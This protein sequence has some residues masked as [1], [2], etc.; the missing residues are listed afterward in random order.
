MNIMSVANKT[1]PPDENSPGNLAVTGAS[2]TTSITSR[3]RP[4]LS[5]TDALTQAF[6]LKAL[7]NPTRLRILNLL[8]RYEGVVSVFDIVEN[9]P[10]EQPTISHHLRILRDAGLIDYE[11][12]GLW[13]YYYVRRDALQRAQDIIKNLG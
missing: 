13:A 2:T 5:E 3:F 1:P 11:K 7:A 6:L 8:T 9:F 10:L 4:D 12:K